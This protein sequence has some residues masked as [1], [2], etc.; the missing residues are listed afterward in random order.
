M[1]DVVGSRGTPPK[2]RARRWLFPF[3]V[4]QFHHGKVPLDVKTWI[5]QIRYKKKEEFYISKIKSVFTEAYI[6]MWNIYTDAA[7]KSKFHLNGRVRT[8]YNTSS[9]N[10]DTLRPMS[11]EQRRAFRPFRQT[12]R[13]MNRRTTTPTA[14]HTA[15]TL[16]PQA[17]DGQIEP[18]EIDES[19]EDLDDM[20]H[21]DP[22]T[23]MDEFND[24]TQPHDD[25]FPPTCIG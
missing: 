8:L 10:M 1:R 2:H 15:G 16:T 13:N 22:M 24:D 4:D 6:E 18:L 11:I 7:A 23:A 21:A 12:V 3:P 17:R 5:S 20:T 19:Q 14:E 25:P 9:K